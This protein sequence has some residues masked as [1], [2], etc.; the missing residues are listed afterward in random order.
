LASQAAVVVEQTAAQFGLTFE[1]RESLTPDDS[2]A[3]VVILS[4]LPDLAAL[5][6]NAPQ[7]QFV[8]VGQA[9]LGDA[10]NLTQISPDPKASYQI[11]FLGGY[12]AAMLTEDWRVGTIGT[13]DQPGYTQGFLNG[14]EYFCGLCTQLYPP[15]YEYPLYVTLEAG[16]DAGAW[17]S[18]ADQLLSQSVQTIFVAPGAGNEALLTYLAGKGV[19]LVGGKSPPEVARDQWILTLQTDLLQTLAQVLP[20]VIQSGGQGQVWAQVGYIEVNPTRISVGRLENLEKM[21]EILAE[22]II[23]PEGE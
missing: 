14:A 12:V 11:G 10:P 16:V 22:G 18:A 3:L 17:Q 1:Q 7:T 9:G 19:A 8:A 20:Q 23:D 15:F 4:S 13:T 6:A 21:I 2:A 5:I